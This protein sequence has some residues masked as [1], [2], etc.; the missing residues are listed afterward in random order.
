MYCHFKP[1]LA[2]FVEEYGVSAANNHF[3][4]QVIAVA[5]KLAEKQER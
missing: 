1:I 2:K 3:C 5:E 4:E